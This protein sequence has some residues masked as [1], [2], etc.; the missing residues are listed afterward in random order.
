MKKIVSLILAV[1]M[2][3]AILSFTSC[4]ETTAAVVEKAFEKTENLDSY[5]AVMDV[6]ISM[7]AGP[8]SMNI[9]M[10]VEYKVEGAKTESP[11][12]YAKS[13]L[14]MFEESMTVE[15]YIADG[16]M[17]VVQGDNKF[18]ADI[19]KIDDYEAYDY[20]AFYDE[21]MQELPESL[22]DN[23]EFTAE[24]D[25]TQTVTLNIPDAAFKEIFEDFL[26]E[27]GELAVQDEV[28]KLTT[29][30]GKVSLSVKDGYVSV[31]SM[32]YTMTIGTNNINMDAN[33]SAVMTFKNPG[34]KVSV[35]LPSGAETFP[36]LTATLS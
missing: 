5:E 17:Y 25:G 26:G 13:T 28:D 10:T 22:F 30:N 31:Y 27:M 15:S 34:A 3:F 2:I 8:I 23:V 36:D 21:M 16:W 7:G 33:V 35:T 24:S 20:S 11:K 1:T 14:E 9:P 12:I 29:S 4:G 19:S 18:K 6:T 32:E